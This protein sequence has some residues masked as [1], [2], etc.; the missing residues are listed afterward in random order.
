VPPCTWISL[1]VYHIVR[2]VLGAISG[3]DCGAGEELGKLIIEGWAGDQLPL[4]AYHS[5]LTDKKYIDRNIGT[6]FVPG[7]GIAP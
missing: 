1:S 4:P 6:S 2:I 3:K 5:L 7:R